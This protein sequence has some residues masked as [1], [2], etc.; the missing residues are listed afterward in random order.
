VRGRAVVVGGAL[1]AS[2]QP[3]A[4]L[5]VWSESAGSGSV[6]GGVDVSLK[7]SSYRSTEA[8]SVSVYQQVFGS[9]GPHVGLWKP[10]AHD[11]LL[12]DLTRASAATPATWQ[13]VVDSTVRPALA[14]LGQ[15]V[16]TGNRT[17]TRY[18]LVGR[19]SADPARVFGVELDCEAAL[20]CA[21]AGGFSAEE[22]APTTALAAAQA[23]QVRLVAMAGDAVRLRA[24]GAPACSGSSTCFA[25][26][27]GSTVQLSQPDDTLEAID[28]R[29]EVVEHAGVVSIISAAQFQSEVR[30]SGLRAC[31]ER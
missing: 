11:V 26:T 9:G 28:L 18:V 8:V 3:I 1:D 14:Y 6:I 21:L 13:T 20:S 25:P 10:S 12:S 24:Y 7:A 17:T 22:P 29:L 16:I 19:S 5:Y 4:P 15:R 23:R 30:L 31:E 2:F 27:V